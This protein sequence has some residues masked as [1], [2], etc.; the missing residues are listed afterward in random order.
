MIAQ[1]KRRSCTHRYDHQ[2]VSFWP[3][4]LPGGFALAFVN[5]GA[6]VALNGGL[7]VYFAF[8]TRASGKARQQQPITYAPADDQAGDDAVG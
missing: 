7:A 1:Q 6:S 2:A 8:M 4:L 3:T 5:V